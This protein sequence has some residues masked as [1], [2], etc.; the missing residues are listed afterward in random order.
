[1]SNH[2]DAVGMSGLGD[3]TPGAQEAERFREDL[4]LRIVATAETM[5]R[6]LDGRAETVLSSLRKAAANGILHE[7][8][9]AV[10]MEAVSDCVEHLRFTYNWAHVMLTTRMVDALKT[11][12]A[13]LV[14]FQP[15]AKSSDKGTPSC[16]R[17]AA[18]IRRLGAEF[19]VRFTIEFSKCP[20][21]DSFLEG[22]VIARNKI[23]HNGAMAWQAASN[24]DTIV[25]EGTEEW[26][27]WK[28]DREFVAEF[29]EYV[30]SANRIT[31]SEELFKAN[32]ERTMAF[33]TWVGE[34]IDSFVQL[35]T[36][37]SA[38]GSPS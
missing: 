4:Y 10:E 25:V 28:C 36:K 24:P 23:V 30:D 13:H 8:R 38:G 20:N 32:A 15:K 5:A 3:W 7:D 18:E 37:P 33:I 26:S 1:M 31:V 16:A 17:R 11:W 35:V 9:E 29:R 12:S 22:M 14:D 21:G 27:P 34:H 2:N 6:I 19:A